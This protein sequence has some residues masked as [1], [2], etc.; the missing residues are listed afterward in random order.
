MIDLDGTA[1][2]YFPLFQRL[3]AAVAATGDYL[4]LTNRTI[5]ELN[6]D[7]TFYLDPNGDN[8]NDGTTAQ[9]A[10]RDPQ[11]AAD[12]MAWVNANGHNVSVEFADAIWP[13]TLVRIPGQYALMLLEYRPR[14]CNSFK[15]IGNPT[16]PTAC[17]VD[18]LSPDQAYA[19]TIVGGTVVDEVNGFHFNSSVIEAD[20]PTSNSFYAQWHGAFGIWDGGRVGKGDN[21]SFGSGVHGR[22][23]WSRSFR[24]L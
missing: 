16:T 23:V 19:F 10:W 22:V 24:R 6:Q 8:D 5:I 15:I 1:Y 13:T 11:Y 2:L 7:T 12:R 18:I 17:T 4:D 14:N 21:L 20:Y 3:F 9:S